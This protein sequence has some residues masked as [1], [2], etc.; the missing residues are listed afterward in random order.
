MQLTAQELRTR[1]NIT[2]CNWNYWKHYRSGKYTKYT[3]PEPDG[4]KYNPENRQ[5]QSTWE[6]ESFKL[7]WESRPTFGQCKDITDV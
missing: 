5:N 1:L 4:I 2:P 7:W 6:F 3:F